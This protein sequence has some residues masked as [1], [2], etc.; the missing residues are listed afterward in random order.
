LVGCSSSTR[1]IQLSGDQYGTEAI[2]TLVKEMEDKRDDL[3]V[4]VAGYP[5]P[6]EIFIA[7]NPGL[8]SRFRTTIDFADYTDDELVGIFRKLAADADY[9]VSD[10]VE[11]HLRAMLA[12]VQR[13]PTFGNGRYSRNTLEA[14]IGAHAWRL[15]EVEDPDVHALRT[16]EPADLS[17][18]GTELDLAH[19]LV[20][21]DGEQPE[22][23]GTTPEEDEVQP[24]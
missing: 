11:Q 24:S 9:D 20:A 7:Q 12:Q 3:V 21:Q 19:P 14:A 5:V 17:P 16:L 6:M 1:P 8:A 23:S 4:I 15:R 18:D 22:H 2:D 13:G 10:D